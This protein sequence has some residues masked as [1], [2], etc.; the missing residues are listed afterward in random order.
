MFSSVHGFRSLHYGA[1]RTF[2]MLCARY[3]GHGMSLNSVQDLVAQCPLCQKD[4]LPLVPLPN[5]SIRQTLLHHHRTI[6]IDHVTVSPPS[7]DGYVGLLLIVEHDTKFP[8]AYPIKDYSAIV[9]AL[10]LFRHYCTFGTFTRVFSDPGTSLLAS[11]VSQL[12]TWLNI[13]H[14]VSLVGRHESNGTEHVNQLFLGH[15]RRLVHDLRLTH[16]C[17]ALDQSRSLY[18]T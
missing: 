14:H 9:V 3:P 6:G 11:S 2:L 7:E 17:S 5:A 4:R 12:N 16:K 1:K 10:I 15:L 18:Y 13:P 8:V